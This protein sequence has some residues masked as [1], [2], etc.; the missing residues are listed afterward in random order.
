[1]GGQTRT[2]QSL[3]VLRVDPHEN[4]LYV[5]GSVP[6]P[7]GTFIKVKDAIRK[8]ERKECFPTAYDIPYPS[9]L[10]DV[11]SLEAELLPK[12]VTDDVKDLHTL[13]PLNRPYT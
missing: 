12:D 5:T 11:A 6:G 4:L 10:G 13:D 1:M 7:D 2:I 8:I 9:F 3:R